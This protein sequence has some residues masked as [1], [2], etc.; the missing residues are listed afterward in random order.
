MACHFICLSL[1][2]PA[3]TRRIKSPS[4]LNKMETRCAR[5]RFDARNCAERRAG[6]MSARMPAS[7]SCSDFVATAEGP[8]YGFR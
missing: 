4:G 3:V 8:P 6:S 1:R 2:I 5:L 7:F